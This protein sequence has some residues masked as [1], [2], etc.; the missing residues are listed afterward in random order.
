MLKDA[1]ELSVYT[2]QRCAILLARL[3]T[4]SPGASD[5]VLRRASIQEL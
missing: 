3:E 1:E 2:G 4:L 5:G